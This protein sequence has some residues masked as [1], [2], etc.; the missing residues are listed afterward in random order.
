MMRLDFE[1]QRLESR[2][3]AT[4]LSIGSEMAEKY[5]EPLGI[6]DMRDVRRQIIRAAEHAAYEAIQRERQYHAGDMAMLR[7][8]AEAQHFEAMMT[9]R[10]ASVDMLPQ[11]QDRNGLDA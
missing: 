10:P 5:F 1:G 3:R 7:K 4:A 2:D 8:W 11:G 6:G 9:V